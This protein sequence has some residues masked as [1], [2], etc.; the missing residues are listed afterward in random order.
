MKQRVSVGPALISSPCVA[1]VGSGMLHMTTAPQLTLMFLI[2]VVGLGTAFVWMFWQIERTMS[3][4][5]RMSRL[6]RKGDRLG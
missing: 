3:R 2:V 6:H 1:R 5:R 4:L